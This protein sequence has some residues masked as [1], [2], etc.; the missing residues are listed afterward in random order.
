DYDEA[1]A[2]ARAPQ[3]I[4]H[5]KTIIDASMK[6]K[7]VAAGLIERSHRVAAVANKNGLFGYHRSADSQLTTT[8]RMP[9]GSS[10]GWAGQPSTKLSEIDSAHLA[11]T[12]S[13]KCIRWRNPQKLEPGNY[14]VLLEPTAAGDLVRLMAGA[15]S[16]RDTEEGRT[17]LSKRGGGT[18]LGEK[19]FPDFVNLRIDPFDARQPSQ[20]WTGDLLPTRAISWVDKGVIANLA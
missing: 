12:A 8:I 2:V 1:T 6:Q 9:D 15:F 17:F 4:P 5:V 14:T 11:A 16:A 7:L 19:S 18:F 3:M 13:E 20:P 10:S